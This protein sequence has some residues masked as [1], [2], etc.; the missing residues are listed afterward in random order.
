MQYPRIAAARP[1]DEI[2]AY[3]TVMPRPVMPFHWLIKQDS[4]Q[5]IYSLF[6]IS[7]QTSQQKILPKLGTS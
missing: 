1:W 7:L 3:E 5:K 4:I 6:I 2:Q